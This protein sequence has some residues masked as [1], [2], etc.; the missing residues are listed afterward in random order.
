MLV[1]G[2]VSGGEGCILYRY[3]TVPWVSGDR[4]ELSQW[5]LCGFALSLNHD[6]AH[7]RPRMKISSMSSLPINS[8]VMRGGG[9]LLSSPCPS[10][11]PSSTFG[12]ESCISC[13][14]L[15]ALHFWCQ[16]K[17]EWACV[18]WPC[19]CTVHE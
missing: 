13:E 8:D 4:I 2:T 14:M 7:S 3:C 17:E 18:R 15:N 1:A 12:I 11:V 10:S 19:M 16:C 5:S 6:A 9:V